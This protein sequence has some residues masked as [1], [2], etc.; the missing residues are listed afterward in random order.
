MGLSVGDGV[1]PKMKQK[2][3]A[4]K[5]DAKSNPVDKPTPTTR[6]AEDFGAV[7]VEDFETFDNTNV[8][9]LRDAHSNQRRQFSDAEDVG[10]DIGEEEEDDADIRVGDDA[11]L[12]G[13][14]KRKSGSSTG[15][16]DTSSNSPSIRI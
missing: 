6:T 5:L 11:D 3:A 7:D 4:Q 1:I 15:P 13:S 12:S 14:R 2:L 8:N 9:A 10:E 16:V